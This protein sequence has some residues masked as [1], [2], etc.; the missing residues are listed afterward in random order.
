[1]GKK[2]VL[3][4]F[5]LRKPKIFT[6]FD[7]DNDHGVS[8]WLIGKDNF[9]DIIKKTNYDNLDIILAGPVPPNPSELLA[10]E[11]TEELLKL[12][13]KKYECIIIDSAPIGTVS[14]T[15]HLS[16]FADTSILVV[17]QNMTLKDL[18]ENTIKELKLSDI[19]SL[20]VVVND[21][22]PDDNRYRYGGKYGY[23]YEK[24]KK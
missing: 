3:V 23:H 13:K 18:L 1:M 22:G 14:D 7:L 15:L 9:E 24:V 12:L 20:S 17:R 21:L 10:L 4:G 8:T 6:D 5:D 16:P 19:K 2:T 11:K